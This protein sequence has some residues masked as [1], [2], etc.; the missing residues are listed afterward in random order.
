MTDPTEHAVDIRGIADILGISTDTAYRKANL[1]QI[2]GFRVGRSW[3]F[4]PSVVRA[5]LSKPRDPWAYSARA[6]AAQKRR[7]P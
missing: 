1:G 6:L 5:E 2:P 4:F 3:R 7:R